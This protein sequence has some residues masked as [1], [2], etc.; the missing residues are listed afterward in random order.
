MIHRIEDQ[1]LRVDVNSL[2]AELW[3]L[4]KK[5]EDIEY[6]WQGDTEV[7]PNRAPVLFPHCGRLK[8]NRYIHNNR[9]YESPI[10]GFVRDHEHRVVD[11]SKTSI[12]FLLSDSPET[13]KVYPFRFNLYT[14]FQLDNGKLTQSFEVEN[15]QEEVM[16][17]SLG[18]HTGFKVPFDAFHGVEDYSI[19]FEKEESPV[20]LKCNEE[21]LLNGKEEV[22]MKNRRT[23]DVHEG[24]F[25]SS[26]ILSGLK[27]EYVSIVEKD[28][29]R[30]IKVGIKDFPYVVFWSKPKKIHFI[31][32][33]PWYGLPDAADTQGSFETKPGIL[34]LSPGQR[35]SCQMTIEIGK[36]LR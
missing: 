27:S 18:Y 14:R 25:P 1:G 12:T 19:V 32:V 22:Y 31:C 8:E 6:L 15:K 26:F 7:W 29:G 3:S 17:F 11:Q 10:H 21:G 4:Y 20:E 24:L 35:F 16:L 36:K 33:E 28:S 5:E 34:T 2:G 9:I 13:L 23:I 30:E